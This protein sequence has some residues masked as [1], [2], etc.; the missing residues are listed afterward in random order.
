MAEES[1]GVRDLRR[2]RYRLYREERRKK[3]VL[4]AL[5]TEA[6]DNSVRVDSAAQALAAAVKVLRPMDFARRS[7]SESR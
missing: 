6:Y 5:R 7:S 3:R 4:G 2:P 1:S